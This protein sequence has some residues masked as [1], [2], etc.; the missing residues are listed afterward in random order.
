MFR[1]GAGPAAHRRNLAKS[2][3]KRRLFEPPGWQR[4]CSPPGN[5]F[6]I[7]SSQLAIAIHEPSLRPI[8]LTGRDRRQHDRLAVDELPWLKSARLGAGIRVTILDLSEGGAL[9]ETSTR[10]ELGVVVA[11]TLVNE[12]GTQTA[13]LRILRCE[14]ASIKN[15]PI[16]RG[17]GKFEYPLVIPTE[18]TAV[19]AY[20]RPDV[21]KDLDH[22]PPG[23]NKLVVRYLDGK[24]LKGV[25]HDFHPSRGHFHLCETIGLL[26]GPPMLVPMKQLKAVFVVKD[27]DGDATY[28]ERKSFDAA[29]PGRRIEVTFL[30]GEVLRG[31]TL[32]YRPDGHGFFMTPADP[33]ANNERV[34]VVPSAVRHFRYV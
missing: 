5:H 24:L 21:P 20:E 18:G 34:F 9:I 16:Y 27:F 28:Q 10:L 33:N 26:S 25:S 31:T 15:G 17:A 1:N 19:L 32:S 23:W 3:E 11:L 14:L 29:V 6:A 7:M 2:L 4:R 30:D 13:S 12:H 8:E 22:L